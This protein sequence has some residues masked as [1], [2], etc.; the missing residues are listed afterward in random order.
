[1]SPMM[2]V[3]SIVSLIGIYSIVLI[4][5]AFRA[6]ERRDKQCRAIR[7]KARTFKYIYECDQ[8]IDRIGRL[9]KRRGESYYDDVYP[10]QAKKREL[11]K[12][13]AAY[14]PPEVI[15][16]ACRLLNIPDDS[17]KEDVRRA[18]EEARDACSPKELRRRNAP[19]GVFVTAQS[20]L[21]EIRN[22]ESL[23]L[24]KPKKKRL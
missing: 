14:A 6:A 19:K 3:L 18:A 4:V 8:A 9:Y 23:L 16:S 21:I 10:I 17:C 11:L 1:M 12:A 20:R 24:N 2:M 22:A 7:I 5:R 13:G 15:A